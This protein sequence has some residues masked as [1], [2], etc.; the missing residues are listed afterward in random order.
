MKVFGLFLNSYFTV[1]NVN[2]AKGRRAASETG[3]VTGSY[4]ESEAGAGTSGRGEQP[5]TT[6]PL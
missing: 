3:Q 4:P 6:G 2:F 1:V 5:Y